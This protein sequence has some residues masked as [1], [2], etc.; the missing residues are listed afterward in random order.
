M[1]LLQDELLKGKESIIVK[2]KEKEKYQCIL[3]KVNSQ[4]EV[5]I[6]Y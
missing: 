3:P 1:V 2:T 4:D 5:C 6:D